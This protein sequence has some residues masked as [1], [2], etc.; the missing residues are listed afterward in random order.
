MRT[1]FALPLLLCAILPAACDSSTEPGAE[2][3]VVLFTF[4]GYPADTMRVLMQHG[5]TIQEARRVI[6]G[7]SD[8]T[9]PIGPI[10]RGSGVDPRYPYHFLPD[11]VRLAGMTIE[12]CDGAPMHT[13]AEVDE[14]FLGSTGDPNASQAYWCPW[15]A[16][17]I[18]IE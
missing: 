9:I 14:F 17:P 8:A 7:E 6:A 16:R 18:A 3:A 13:A 2:E 1:R 10:V 4:E 15:N 5:P 12:L 11:E